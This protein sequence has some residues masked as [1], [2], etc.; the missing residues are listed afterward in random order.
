MRAWSWCY[1]HVEHIAERGVTQGYFDGLYHPEYTCTRD[2][3]AVYI[4]RAFHLPM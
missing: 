1:D 3:M 2:Q 4:C